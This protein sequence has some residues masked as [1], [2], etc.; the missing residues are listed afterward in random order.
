MSR[1][2]FVR[3]ARRFVLAIPLICVA[4]MGV[5]AASA[6][7]EVASVTVQ[8]SD[9]SRPGLL[10]MDLLSGSITVS[11]HAKSDVV[12]EYSS[13]TPETKDEERKDGEMFVIR[14]NA[15]NFEVTENDNVMEFEMDSWM[16]NGVSINVKVPVNISLKLE[17][18]NNGDLRVEGVTGDVELSSVNGSI[19]ATGIS[20]LVVA[21]TVN[22][23]VKVEFDKITPDRYMAFSSHNGTIDVTFPPDVKADVYLDTE[24]GTIY[25]DFKIVLDRSPVVV[26][27]DKDERGTR[28]KVDK[29]M[30][31][32]L[33]GGGPEIRFETYNGSIYI[34][35]S[36]GRVS[37]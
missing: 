1:Y 11:V 21:E 31:G 23:S 22:G 28:I 14:N 30:R 15:F 37:D 29:Q 4:Q 26:S 20:G 5:A 6:A 13:D 32:T 12:F 17:S 36:T 2:R 16:D 25:S 27:E 18:V 34:R 24:R 8:F 19:E 7:P 35:S 33:N 10:K 3:L 9:P